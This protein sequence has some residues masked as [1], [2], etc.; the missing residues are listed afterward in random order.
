LV[1]LIYPL[2]KI[3]DNPQRFELLFFDGSQPCELFGIGLNIIW[4]GDTVCNAIIVHLPHAMAPLQFSVLSRE[5][6]RIE[7]RVPFD[8]VLRNQYQQLIFSHLHLLFIY[9]GFFDHFFGQLFLQFS[10]E[11]VV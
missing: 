6:R 11:I 2:L 10:V 7:S 1:R 5:P 8:I 3:A 9:S 4:N